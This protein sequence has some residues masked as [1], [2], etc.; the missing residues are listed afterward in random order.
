ML[1]DKRKFYLSEKIELIEFNNDLNYENLPY[2]FGSHKEFKIF[3]YNLKK[4]DFPLDTI[5]K[6]TLFQLN[7]WDIETINKKIIKLPHSNYLK[8]LNNYL[9]LSKNK[10]F[11]KYK[12]FDYRIENQLILK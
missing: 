6:Y 9:D 3:Y 11:K 7:R 4:I 10:N 1:N 5:K 8:S 2:V 12:V